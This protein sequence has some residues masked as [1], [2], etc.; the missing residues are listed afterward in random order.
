VAAAATA[1]EAT[2]AVTDRL[3]VAL[4]TLATFFVLLGFLAKEVESSSTGPAR[5]PVTVLRRVYE[6]RV[7]ETI[8]PGT[9]VRGG[10]TSVTQSVSGSASPVA[11]APTTRTS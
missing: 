1:T 6:T 4:L 11:A 5:R 8:P 7:I 2:A 9:N 3:T 10:A